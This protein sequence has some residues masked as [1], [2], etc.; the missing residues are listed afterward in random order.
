MALEL[1]LSGYLG[2]LLPE[3][4]W[5]PLKLPKVVRAAA[6]SLHPACRRTWSVSLADTHGASHN[7]IVAIC[8]VR[9]IGEARQGM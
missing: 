9:K 2:S 5:R 8:I 7:F 4:T 6:S 3:G 1:G